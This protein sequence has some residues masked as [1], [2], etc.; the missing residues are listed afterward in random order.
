ML[1]SQ[2]R[3]GDTSL[4][5]DA[6]STIPLLIFGQ[7]GNNKAQARALAFLAPDIQRA[8][9]DMQ[10]FSHGGQSLAPVRVLSHGFWIETPAVIRN[11]QAQVLVFDPGQDADLS[12][13][14]A[15]SSS[16]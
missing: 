6:C 16:L 4:L 11:E 3:R 13:I 8:A 1:P 7:G 15:N 2:V 14:P 10:P 9:H 12:P 5:S